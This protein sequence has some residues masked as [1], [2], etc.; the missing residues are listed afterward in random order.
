MKY[1]KHKETGLKKH[2]KHVHVNEINVS[3]TAV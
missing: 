1:T 3:K 2:E